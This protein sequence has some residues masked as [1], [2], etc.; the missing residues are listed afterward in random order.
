[1]LDVLIEN[2]TVID[3]TGAKAYTG[4]VGI[5]NGRLTLNKAPARTVI[6][7][8]GLTLLPGF[9]D[10]HSH[11]DLVHNDFS[12][13]SKL[14]QGITTE[15]CGQCGV[16][17]WP[18]AEEAVHSRFAAGICPHPV[19]PPQGARERFSDYLK[20]IDGSSRLNCAMFV[21][22]GALRLAVMGYDPAKPSAAQLNSMKALL[23]EAMQGGALGLSTG[24]VYTPNRY[25]CADEVIALLAP[26]RELGGIYATHVRNEGDSVIEAEQEALY[27]AKQA[28]MPLWIS[29]LK[30]AGRQNWG[31]PGR[32]L[33]LFDSAIAGGMSLT[34]D[35]YP[36]LA[37]MTS[38]NVSIPPRFME[39]GAD[40][41]SARLN[42]PA[43]VNA[44]RA[45]IAVQAGYD[46][47]VFNSGGFGGVMVGSCPYFHAAEGMFISDY[48]KSV[49]LGCC[50]LPSNRRGHG[51]PAGQAR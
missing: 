49:G 45:E 32:I 12:A 33:E 30:A 24:L 44:I 37:G 46:N 22:H 36:Y 39:G 47:Y 43:V 10:A 17:M 29:H 40:A 20:Y 42:D 41:L 13:L 23:R 6:D 4:N 2:C 35:C 18:M 8:R 7:G 11:G 50:G 1:M 16:S 51:R 26:V 15:A 28:R 21:G 34:V 25:A 3:G 5:A 9:I 27:I 14:S 19:L 31:K 48:A 38:L